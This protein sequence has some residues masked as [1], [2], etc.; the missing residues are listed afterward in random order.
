[1]TVIH[2]IR[3]TQVASTLWLRPDG[4]RADAWFWIC[5]CRRQ[6]PERTTERSAE[7]GGAQHLRMV[8]R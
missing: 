4:R 5:S 8:E 1:M 2:R 3:I 6:G 7:K